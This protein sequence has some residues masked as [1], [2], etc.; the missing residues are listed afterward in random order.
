MARVSPTS[1]LSFGTV[2]LPRTEYKVGSLPP[3]DMS[4][5]DPS[6]STSY[7]TFLELIQ[8]FDSNS[9]IKRLFSPQSNTSIN[10]AEQVKQEQP[11][12]VTQQ[13][14][15]LKG[16]PT[17]IEARAKT[18]SEEWS[19]EI[20]DCFNGEDSLCMLSYPTLRQKPNSPRP[21]NMLLPLLHLRQNHA[22]NPR[23]LNGYI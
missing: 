18:G 5:Q 14:K 2:L 20:F 3:S 4:R 23:A 17:M 12:V 15:A 6:N 1:G 19:H 16:M 9:F 10:M 13:P 8:P 11:D 22:P 7:S 21:Q